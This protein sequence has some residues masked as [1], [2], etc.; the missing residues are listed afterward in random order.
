MFEIKKDLEVKNMAKITNNNSGKPSWYARAKVR[1]IDKDARN[2]SVWAYMSSVTHHGDMPRTMHCEDVAVE[3]LNLANALHLQVSEKE[4]VRAAL[5][6]DGF[7]YDWKIKSERARFHA[8]V[9]GRIAAKE[10]QEELS[11]TR[12]ERNCIKSHMFPASLDMP[13]SKEAWLVTVADKICSVREYKEAYGC[14]SFIKAFI[15][16]RIIKNYQK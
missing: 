8:F 10:A 11:L 9:H 14:S 2:T 15:M 13:A 6:H 12:K 16:V 7:R 4:L 1:A 5:L 3:A